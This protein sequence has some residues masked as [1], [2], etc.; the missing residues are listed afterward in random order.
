MDILASIQQLVVLGSLAII[1]I[2]IHKPENINI[3]PNSINYSPIC[4]Q[5]NQ[6]KKSNQEQKPSYSPRYYQ[7]HKYQAKGLKENGNSCKL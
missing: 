2:S 6:E 5:A 1:F 4:S 3:Y 7:A